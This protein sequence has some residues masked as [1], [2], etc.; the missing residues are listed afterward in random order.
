MELITRPTIDNLEKI[1]SEIAGLLRLI[2]CKRVVFF[3]HD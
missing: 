3:Y 2:T 1:P